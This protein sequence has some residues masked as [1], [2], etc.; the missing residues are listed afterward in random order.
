MNIGSSAFNDTSDTSGYSLVI[1]RCARGQVN[2]VDG[3]CQ[4][5]NSDNAPTFQLSPN[6]QNLDPVLISTGYVYGPFSPVNPF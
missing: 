6:N 5:A 3:R 4:Y 2:N 1:E